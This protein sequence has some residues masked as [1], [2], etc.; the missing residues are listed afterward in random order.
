MITGIKRKRG[1]EL[2]REQRRQTNEAII[3]AAVK[4]FSAKLYNEVSVDDL[5]REAGVSRV[6]F[7]AHFDGKLSLAF[8]IWNQ[9]IS[10]WD[11]IYDL[12]ATLTPGNVA[13]ASDWI[14]R[15]RAKYRQGGL[16]PSLF[17][18]VD[19]FED[20]FRKRLQAV[21]D[22]TIDR[23]ASRGA[24]GF[25]RTQGDSVQARLARAHAHLIFQRID[26]LCH[27]LVLCA[28]VAYAD[29]LTRMAALELAAFLRGAD[30]PAG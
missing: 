15:L 18:Q 9:S 21:R 16:V 28:P 14:E 13:E 8:A 22:A 6:S 17:A 5:V 24:P 7:Y 30:Y 4:L 26:Q 25:T 10:E 1:N 23:L 3:S 19:L 12:L 20:E 29:A 27:D 11:E 2:Q